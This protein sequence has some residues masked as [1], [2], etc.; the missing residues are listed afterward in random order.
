[1]LTVYGTYRYPYTEALF[2]TLYRANGYSWHVEIAGYEAI[3]VQNVVVVVV[4]KHLP[5][6]TQQKRSTLSS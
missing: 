6:S 4:T 2:H 1:M 3:M 5:N